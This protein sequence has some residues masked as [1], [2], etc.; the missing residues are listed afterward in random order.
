IFNHYATNGFY[1]KGGRHYWFATNLSIRGYEPY[2]FCAN[3]RHSSQEIINVSKSKY[4][5]SFSADVPHVFVKSVNYR[6][7]GFDRIC[8][9]AGFYRNLFPVAKDY[10]KK[11]GKPDVIIASSVHPLTMVAGIQI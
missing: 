8:N 9:M 2:I 5:V 3:T 1:N 6:G 4:A 10:A 7:N 11:H